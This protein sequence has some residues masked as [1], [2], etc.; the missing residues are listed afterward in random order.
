MDTESLMDKP[1]SQKLSKYP[2]HK[3]AP[4][5][6]AAFRHHGSSR[7]KVNVRP[8]QLTSPCINVARA[9]ENGDVSLMGSPTHVEEVSVEHHDDWHDVVDV[10]VD[11]TPTPGNILTRDVLQSSL[12]L[13]YPTMDA[14]VAASI[15][16]LLLNPDHGFGTFQFDVLALCAYLPS[17]TLVLVSHL[18]FSVMSFDGLDMDVLLA[19]VRAVDGTY[20]PAIP[21]HNADH[22][23]DVVHSL[24]CVVVRTPLQ[25]IL[26]APMQISGLLA[27]ITH[28]AAHFGRTNLFLKKSNHRLATMYPV[29]CPLE[30]MHAAVGLELF[31]DHNV[32]GHMSPLLQSELHLVIHSAIFTTSLCEQKNL[33]ASLRAVDKSSSSFDVVLLQAALHAADLGQTTKPFEVHRLW[34]NRLGDELFEQGDAEK[35]L[36]WT[37][38]SPMCDRSVG[39]SVGGQLFFM[40]NLVLPVYTALNERLDGALEQVLRQIATNVDVWKHT[41]TS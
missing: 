19:W 21:Y 29:C 13:L 2:T 22:A 40:Q 11:S 4:D 10:H 6:I 9:V 20:N 23:A 31:T 32:L 38:V 28:D 18:I 7:S 15:H 16:T 39:F 37:D 36:G 1:T 12:D 35:A 27:A 3:S 24:Y 41:M 26:S 34:V 17:S 14:D 30:E 25:S 33:L 8:I 5:V